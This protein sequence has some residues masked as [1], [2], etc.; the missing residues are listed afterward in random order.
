MVEYKNQN[1]SNS[2]VDKRIGQNNRNVSVED[3]SLMRFSRES[4]KRFDETIFDEQTLPEER[5]THKGQILSE[6]EKF[7]DPESDSDDDDQFISKKFVNEVH[8][9]DGI[10]EL[11]SRKRSHKEL[12]EDM[13]TDSKIRKA[14]LRKVKDETSELTKQLDDKWM[15]ILPLIGKSDA[16]GD[17]IGFNKEKESDYDKMMGEL[18]FESCGLPSSRLKSEEEVAKD[19]REKLEELENERLK[20]MCGL[21]TVTCT[22]KSA[23]DLDDDY[24]SNSDGDGDG[25][26]DEDVEESDGGSE[27]D[28]GHE[29]D[30]GND[31][32]NLLELKNESADGDSVEV[33]STSNKEIP[34]VIPIPKN[35]NAFQELIK[36]HNIEEQALVIRRII[37]Y[38][39]P[40]LEQGNKEKLSLLLMY[41]V[42]Y[43]LQLANCAGNRFGEALQ[44]L[45]NN[46]GNVI[47][48]GG[49]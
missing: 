18:I 8:F 34:Y 43:C 27:Q 19:E 7:E 4:I 49:G 28:D 45:D 25:D 40:K 22:H 2:F 26:G 23:D 30:K 42:K 20:R 24:D 9:G 11:N 39:N 6:I 16:K 14:E 38:N 21:K 15:E 44:F 10:S 37:V 3:R 48:G 33:E 12:I 13:I 5:I 32:D 1:K 35:Y 46:L 47:L 29:D 17:L 41:T 36:D 31:N